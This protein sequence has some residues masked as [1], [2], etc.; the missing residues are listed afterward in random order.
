MESELLKKGPK[1]LQMASMGPWILVHGERIGSS[2][3]TRIMVCFNGAMDFS[4]WRERIDFY[5]AISTFFVHYF[6]QNYVYLFINLIL[7]IEM[8]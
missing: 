1:L 3:A 5:I 6:K 2:Q 4:P 7:F 8:Y